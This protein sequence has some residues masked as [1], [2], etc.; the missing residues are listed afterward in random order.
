MARFPS[1][2]FR[3]WMRNTFRLPSSSTRGTTKQLRPASSRANTRKTSDIGAE[4]NHLCPVSRKPPSPVGVA[5]VVLART[6]EPPCFSVIAMPAMSPRFSEGLRRPKSYSRLASPGTQRSA[7]AG[8][9]CSAGTAAYVIEIGQPCPASTWYQAE[10]PA[11]RSTCA[12]GRSETHG[13]ACSPEFT[14]TVIREC[15]AGWNSTSSIR[16]PK[17]SWV[18]SVGVF[19]SAC[20][21]HRR[22]SGEPAWAPIP[23][24]AE[25]SPPKVARASCSTGSVAMTSRAG[26]GRDWFSTSWVAV[27]GARIALRLSSMLIV[28]TVGGCCGA[29][30]VAP[31]R[32]G[33]PPPGRQRRWSS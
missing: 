7:M 15:H 12:A 16:W 17:R 27:P 14:A 24:N 19:V 25:A 20:A 2:S 28:V 33:G 9:T 1:L 26:I 5:V 11:A 22:A 30:G 3:R 32:N 13:A 29:C 21:A 18:C 23:A 10:K 6:S 4:Q 31:P 8:S